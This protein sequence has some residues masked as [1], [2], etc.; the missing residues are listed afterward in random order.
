MTIFLNR[1]AQG[2]LEKEDFHSLNNGSVLV[3]VGKFESTSETK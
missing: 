3:T 1:L 2:V